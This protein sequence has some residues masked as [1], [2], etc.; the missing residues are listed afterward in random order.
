MSS[1][2]KIHQNWAL[3]FS[4]WAST[5]GWRVYG[6]QSFLTSWSGISFHSN[7]HRAHP[8]AGYDAYEV[9]AYNA[10]HGGQ[11]SRPDCKGSVSNACTPRAKINP[12]FKSCFCWYW[13][14]AMVKVTNTFPLSSFPCTKLLTHLQQSWVHKSDPFLCRCSQAEDLVRVRCHK[15][16]LGLKAPN[17]QMVQTWKSGC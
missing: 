4:V 13:V 17:S 5:A 14:T 1:N 10:S 7:R 16:E 2:R 8:H 3:S 9:K 15:R 12:S 6:V 11:F